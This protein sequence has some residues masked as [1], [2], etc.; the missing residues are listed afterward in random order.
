MGS[1]LKALLF[2]NNLIT[3]ND[4]APPSQIWIAKKIS[5]IESG[6]YPKYFKYSINQYA[7]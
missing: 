2:I 1:E 6:N 3:G 7:Q 4:D 5:A